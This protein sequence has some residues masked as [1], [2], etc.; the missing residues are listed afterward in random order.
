[1]ETARKRGP[2]FI[3]SARDCVVGGSSSVGS[4]EKGKIRLRLR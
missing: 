2:T 3:D 4:V 1:M